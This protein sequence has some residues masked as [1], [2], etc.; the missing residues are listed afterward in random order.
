M[1]LFSPACKATVA[2]VM[3]LLENTNS[4]EA[5]GFGAQ[6]SLV[7]SFAAANT[8]GRSNLQLGVIQHGQEA[9]LKIGLTSSPDIESLNDAVDSIVYMSSE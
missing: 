3:F 1:L 7:Q 8:I 5:S 2:D 9:I 4:V 6:K